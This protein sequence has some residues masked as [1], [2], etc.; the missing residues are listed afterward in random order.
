MENLV[1]RFTMK[2]TLAKEANELKHIAYC[3][4]LITYTPKALK[5]LIDNFQYY[6]DALYNEDVYAYFKQIINMC[7]HGGKDDMKV[8]V[9]QLLLEE[10][11][12]FLIYFVGINYRDGRKNW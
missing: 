10:C 3:L 2:F 9:L 1:E 12:L 7:K 5:N 11:L 8:T 6:R 4:S